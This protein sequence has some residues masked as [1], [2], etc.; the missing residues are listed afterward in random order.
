M[1]KRMLALGLAGFMLLSVLTVFAEEADGDDLL[2][3]GDEQVIED[4]VQDDG[5]GEIVGQQR[6]RVA[7]VSRGSPRCTPQKTTKYTTPILADQDE[8]S[9]VL[10]TRGQVRKTI[11][12]YRVFPAYV[13]A[14]ANGVSG[15]HFAHPDQ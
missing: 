10:G 11:T 15:F 13:L 1:I 2:D 14:E 12:V 3:I 6:P 8:D 7:G 5:M 4:D 9:K